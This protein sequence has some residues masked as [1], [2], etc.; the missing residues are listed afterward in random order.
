MTR[1]LGVLAAR[2]VARWSVAF[3]IGLEGSL[4]KG[5]H[6]GQASGHRLF[7]Q[8]ITIEKALDERQ[9]AE[10]RE[11]GAV[12]GEQE[13]FGVVAAEVPGIHL[14]FEVLHGAGE[15]RLECYSELDVAGA[16]LGQG[17]PNL[18]T[19]AFPF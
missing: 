2:I 11:E 14:P 3:W 12:S 19:I 15:E 4:E 17:L 9:I 16:L 7:A 13:L 10:V 5:P 1:R 18:C 6:M 8:W